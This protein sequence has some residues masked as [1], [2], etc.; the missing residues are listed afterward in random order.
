MVQ[1]PEHGTLRKAGQEWLALKKL[2]HKPLSTSSWSGKVTYIAK[3]DGCVGW[4]KEWLFE[5]PGASVRVHETRACTEVKN[6]R[7]LQRE[8][9]KAYA[10]RCTPAQALLEM[11]R[12]GVPVEQ[13]PPAH[14]LQNYRPSRGKVQDRNMS[15][16][17]HSL[18]AFCKDPPT[19]VI[20]EEA[21]VT[22]TPQEVRLC[23]HF[24]VSED[25][26]GKLRLDTWVMD[27][28]LRTNSSGLALGAVGPLGLRVDKAGVPHLRMVPLFFCLARQEDAQAHAMLLESFFKSAQKCDLSLSHGFVDCLCYH[29]CDKALQAL[30]V[31]S[32]VQLHRCLQHTK[33]NLKE[34]ARRR[35]PASG[36][37]RLKNV[38]LGPMLKDWLVQS[39]FLPSSLEFTT[40]WDCVLA[41]LRASG[42]PT[43]WHEPVIAAYIEKHLL[44]PGAAGF[45]AL[46]RSGYGSVPSGF[47]TY[48]SNT[49][50]R[51]WRTLKGVLGNRRESLDTERRTRI[52][53]MTLFPDLFWV[54]R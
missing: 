53:R 37:P 47:S 21:S 52:T 36:E 19:H 44:M 4:N 1:L 15:D 49:L 25:I 45:T 31:R 12:A 27:F 32:K 50:E 8:H 5:S 30:G 13:R 6:V 26:L 41:R 54:V 9:A 14:V 2:C 39:A 46:W 34:E 48:A 7:R 17:L 51:T 43:D 11:E 10:A 33:E 42:K 22:C 35:D 20:V 18:Q 3:C 40:F 38:E 16:C 28:T 23:F 24:D 29:G